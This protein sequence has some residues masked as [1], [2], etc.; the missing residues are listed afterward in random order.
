MQNI[1]SKYDLRLGVK[2]EESSG[3]ATETVI[4]N[5]FPLLTLIHEKDKI[6]Q[7]IPHKTCKFISY[8]HNNVKI[9]HNEALQHVIH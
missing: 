1:A 6:R 4:C 5:L 9:M 7:N 3:Q 8:E 2:I